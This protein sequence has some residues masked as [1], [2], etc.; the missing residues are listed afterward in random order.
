MPA[1]HLPAASHPSAR[2]ANRGARP[3]GNALE[4]QFTVPAATRDRLLQALRA[5]LAFLV[6]QGVMDYSLLVGVAPRRGG[7]WGG[8]DATV[9]SGVG[10]PNPPATTTQPR[11]GPPKAE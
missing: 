5:D 8:P 4:R 3:G 6:D 9:P 7:G 10:G 11:S 1:H 2:H